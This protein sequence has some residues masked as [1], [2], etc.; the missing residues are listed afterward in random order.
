MQQHRIP[1]CHGH[2]AGGRNIHEDGAGKDGSHRDGQHQRIQTKHGVDR[3]QQGMRHGL[4]DVHQGK[5]QPGHGIRHQVAFYR[6][7]VLD[8][9]SAVQCL[10]HP[11][12]WL[13]CCTVPKVV[14]SRSWGIGENLRDVF[15]KVSY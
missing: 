10:S 13:A 14:F 15:R 7:D 9:F 6:F 8:G 3:R 4:G 5:G 12:L 11:F 1:G 2:G